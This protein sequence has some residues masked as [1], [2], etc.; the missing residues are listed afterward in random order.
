MGIVRSGSECV[1]IRAKESIAVVRLGIMF[2]LFP[3]MVFPPHSDLRLVNLI[4]S[5]FT[6]FLIKLCFR[7]VMD[8]DV[9]EDV[10]TPVY[11][12]RSLGEFL[13]SAVINLLST[14]GD[15]S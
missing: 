1:N 12:S 14:A 4:S 6:T 10:F 5:D 11:M 8:V 2:G 15:H 7:C 13:V 9:W 3:F